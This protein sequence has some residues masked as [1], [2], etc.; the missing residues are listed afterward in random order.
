VLKLLLAVIIIAVAVYALVRTVQRRGAQPPLVG[1]RR[2]GPPTGRSG[3]SGRSGRGGRSGRSGRGGATG[4]IG[5]DD[6]EDFLREL[7]RRRLDGDG[8]PD[9]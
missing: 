1:S 2:T 6:D 4:P 8:P 9:G 3:R 7:D 5:P